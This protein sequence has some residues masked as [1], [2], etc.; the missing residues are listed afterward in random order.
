MTKLGPGSEDHNLSSP[1]RKGHQKAKQNAK[2]R[3]AALIWPQAS[4]WHNLSK[5]QVPSGRYSEPSLLL[6]GVGHI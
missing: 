2:K 4:I 3:N 5:W 1:G 6:Y